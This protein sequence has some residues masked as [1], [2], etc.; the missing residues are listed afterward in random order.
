M[1]TDATTA[2]F[3]FAPW[4]TYSDR[5]NRVLLAAAAGLSDA[6]LDTPIAMG[7][8]NLRRT[9]I[10]IYAAEYVWLQRQSGV[11]E[12]PWFDESRALSV[13]E[14]AGMFEAL[15]PGRDRFL[16]G[17]AATQLDVLQPYRDSLGSLYQATLRDMLMQAIV[18]SIHHRAQA[19]NMFRQLGQPVADLD[20]MYSVR[21]KA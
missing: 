1:M 4:T 10:H 3:A 15:W 17:V 7:R 18:H 6:Q 8:G 2:F 12:Q 20:Y 16:Q 13:A 5:M 14:L 9:L 19:A 21:S 11:V